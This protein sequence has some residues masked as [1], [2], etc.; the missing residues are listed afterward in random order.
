MS[1]NIEKRT[2]I[3]MKPNML[4]PLTA[5]SSVE[6]AILRN[7]I[8]LLSENVEIHSIKSFDYNGNMYMLDGDYEML[9]ANILNKRSVDVEIVD[10]KNIP[11]WNVDKNLEENLHAIG[12][13]A[14]FDF[15]AVGGFTYDKYP[16]EY[17]GG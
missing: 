11:F 1:E 8:K 14:L 7:M 17:K 12:V 13:S 10:R 2:Y 9:A 16:K 4:Y 15:E 3:K 5:I 6:P